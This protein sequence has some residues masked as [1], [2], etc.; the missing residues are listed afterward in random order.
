MD[1]LDQL[2]EKYW[3]AI[4]CGVGP[5]EDV[6]KQAL[7]DA[8]VEYSQQSSCSPEDF[9]VFWKKYGKKVGRTPALKKFMKL[10]RVD[11]EKILATVD[12]FVR[13]H[14]DAQYRPHPLTYI[15]QKRWEDEIAGV[16]ERREI[17]DAV[18]QNTWTY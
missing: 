13:A 17:I 5:F 10:K 1:R 9:D 16:S 12:D 3:S 14:P 18:K 6:T 11:I 15:N 7:R 2:A 4:N 8:M